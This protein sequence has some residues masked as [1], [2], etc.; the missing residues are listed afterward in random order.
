V[1]PIPPTIPELPWDQTFYHADL[2][3]P[4]VKEDG[5]NLN[6]GCAGRLVKGWVNVDPNIE[7]P[8]VLN[9]V[10]DDL[11]F[12]K[13]LDGMEYSWPFQD[14]D[15]IIAW[16]SLEHVPRV[17][18]WNTMFDLCQ[19]L[20]PGGHLIICAP[21]ASHSTAYDSPHHVNYFTDVTWGY[22]TKEPYEVEATMG[23]FANEGWTPPDWSIVFNA[24]ILDES[25][26]SDLAPQWQ[27]YR[28]SALETLVVFKRDE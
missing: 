28:N 2:I 12:G 8:Q 7:H 9:A 4:Y 13:V 24:V 25:F 6:Y 11:R 19:I 17:L 14:L 3:R 22:F 21:H 23:Y 18:L 10:A 5:N 26:P 15:T 20:K 1:K 16:H 27:F